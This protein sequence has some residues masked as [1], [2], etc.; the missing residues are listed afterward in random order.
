MSPLNLASQRQTLK[1]N[2]DSTWEKLLSK[3]PD[4]SPGVKSRLLRL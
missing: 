4:I 1:W 3:Q 2:F